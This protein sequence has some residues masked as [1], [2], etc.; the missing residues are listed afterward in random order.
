MCALS[1]GAGPSK[2]LS[3]LPKEL[4]GD[5]VPNFLLLA[6]DNETRL[7]RKGMADEAKKLGAK[8]VVFSF[9]ATWCMNCQTEFFHLKENAAKL[10]ENGVLVYLI[11]S[12]EN[13]MREGKKVG[14]F[15]E[16][17]AGAS[18][19]LYYDQ[20]N[21]LLKGFGI[22]EKNATE[23]ALPVVVVMDANLQVLGAFTETGDD[24]PQVL[25]GNL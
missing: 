5:I 24:F 25:W 17:F 12:G 22:V 23:F 15:A 18:F 13:L 21:N 1:F 9:F 14:S 19:P 6:P 2:K 20:S 8:R 7:N 4:Q 11:N 10:K 3:P 16:K